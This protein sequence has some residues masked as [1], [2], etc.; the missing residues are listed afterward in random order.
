MKFLLVRI[1]RR[2]KQYRRKL[3]KTLESYF[4]VVRRQVW[5]CITRFGPSYPWQQPQKATAILLS[6]KRQRNRN[7]EPIVR[8]LLR[9]NCIDKIIV[10]NNNPEVRMQDWVKLSD[11][12]LHLINQDQHRSCGYRWNI[13]KSEPCEYFLAV[14]DDMLLYP[15]QLTKLFARLLDKPQ[16]P[17]GVI[18]SCYDLNK[19]KNGHFAYSYCKYKE[20]RVDVLHCVYAVTKQHV[21]QYFNY[22]EK[23]HMDGLIEVTHTVR[24]GDDVVMSQTGIGPAVIHDLGKLLHCPSSNVEGVANYLEPDFHS[25]RDSLFVQLRK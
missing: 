3:A 10:S 24:F 25:Y 9:C 2:L 15:K 14:D 18:G 21:S 8:S 22:L 13:A 19:K 1:L 6:Y 12:R 17:H 4:D 23:V 16:V 7:I 20:L 5:S 11:P